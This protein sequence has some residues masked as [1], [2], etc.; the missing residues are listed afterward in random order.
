MV[1]DVEQ[2]LEQLIENGDISGGEIIKINGPASLPV[3][4]VFAHKL[5]HLYQ[6]IACY[7]NIPIFPHHKSQ[8]Y[9]KKYIL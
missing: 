3:A 1:K 6:A 5:S 9:Y 7:S 2:R 8:L 4:M